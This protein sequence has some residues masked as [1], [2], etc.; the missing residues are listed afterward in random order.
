MSAQKKAGH[1][2][3]SPAWFYSGGETTQLPDG[4]IPQGNSITGG[5]RYAE[6]THIAARGR[7]IYI[8]DIA[9]AR[10]CGIAIVPVGGI[11]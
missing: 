11:A 5:A 1:R 2:V 7:E 3:A 4:K 9:V 8:I 6:H 10:G